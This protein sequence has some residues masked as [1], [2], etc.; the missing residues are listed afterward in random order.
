M[1][2]S[3][4]PVEKESTQKGWGTARCTRVWHSGVWLISLFEININVDA[5]VNT[6]TNTNINININTNINGG[7]QECPPY[8]LPA[9]DLDVYLVG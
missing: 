2:K 5:G 7:G 6:N 8:T 3:D 1:Q 9:L 4:D